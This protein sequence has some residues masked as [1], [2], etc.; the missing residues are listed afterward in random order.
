MGPPMCI[1]WLVFQSWGAPG[2][3]DGGAFWAVDTGCFLHGAANSLSSLSPFSNSSIRDHALSLMVGCKIQLCICQVLAEPLRKQLYQAPV[4]KN[5]P[6]STIVSGFG[7]NIW[8]GS[9]G[10]TVDGWPFLQSLL[11]TLFP[12]FL[13]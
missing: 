6:A 4:S 5:F 3:G 2:R 8:D 11:H 13:L 1:L 12:Y 9:P 10:G 7:D